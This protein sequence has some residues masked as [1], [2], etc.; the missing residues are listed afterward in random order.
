ML[1]YNFILLFYLINNMQVETI[2]ATL[3]KLIDIFDEF[4]NAE[5]IKR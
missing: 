2:D 4:K 3:H 5:P 1:L